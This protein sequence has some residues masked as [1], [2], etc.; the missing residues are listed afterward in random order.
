MAQVGFN[1]ARKRYH[2]LFWPAMAV[3][4][5]IVIG[6]AAFVEEGVTPVWITAMVA[7]A[8]AAP[9]A[10]CLWAMVRWMEETDE[11][12][13]IKHLRA[14]ARG[15]ALVA[16]GVFV[17]GFLQLFEVIDT[18]EVFWIGPAFFIAYGLFTCI[19]QLFGKTV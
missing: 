8:T 5:A 11:Y 6:G 17:I 2:R 4:V 16:A 7:V 3:Y 1:A 13:R 9:V 14:F 10:V 12:N 18:F 15:S 19:P